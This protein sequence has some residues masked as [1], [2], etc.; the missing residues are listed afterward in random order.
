MNI[1]HGMNFM[2]LQPNR[3][4]LTAV[5]VTAGKRL[6]SC[7]PQDT[8][9]DDI[10]TEW[11]EKYSPQTYFFCLNQI[12]AYAKKYPTYKDV[13]EFNDKK[14]FR[15]PQELFLEIRLHRKSDF[16]E[17][18]DLVKKTDIKSKIHASFYRSVILTREEYRLIRPFLAR[19]KIIDKYGHELIQIKCE[20][21]IFKKC[22][23]G[24]LLFLCLNYM[25]A[26][27]YLLY[28]G[29]VI[30][31]DKPFL[32]SLIIDFIGGDNFIGNIIMHFNGIIGSGFMVS[33]FIFLYQIVV[34][35]YEEYDRIDI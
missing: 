16:F 32:Q 6:L 3:I 28:R 26:P 12:V 31:L 25:Y 17:W 8:R 19:E 22:V 4:G 2:Q 15:T 11:A 30:I 13:T 35:V 34:Q 24:V 18:M 27:F 1:V 14:K 9:I 29:L 10:L 21:S 23:N 7:N 5:L 20:Q 33:Y